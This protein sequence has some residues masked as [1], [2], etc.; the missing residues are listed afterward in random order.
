MEARPLSRFYHK[1]AD[2]FSGIRGKE[3]K[4]EPIQLILI[5]ILVPC[6]ATLL[7][8]AIMERQL[9]QKT[10]RWMVPNDYSYSYKHL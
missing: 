3:G 5:E 1:D 8:W 10:T 7:F 6:V 4:E 2:F 9:R